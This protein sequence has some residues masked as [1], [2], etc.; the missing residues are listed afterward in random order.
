MAHDEPLAAVDRHHDVDLGGDGYVEVVGQV[1]L[2]VEILALGDP[3][4]CANVAKEGDVGRVQL[5]TRRGS[6][7]RGAHVV[8]RPVRGDLC[9][10][11]LNVHSR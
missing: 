1:A 10:W 11:G 9:V 2:P 8:A 6:D 3:A 5:G 4:L 7:G